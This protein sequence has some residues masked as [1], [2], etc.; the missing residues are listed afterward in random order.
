M[1]A[2]FYREKKR[3]G[4]NI[5][6]PGYVSCPTLYNMYKNTQMYEESNER[7]NPSW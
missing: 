1:N 7:T 6:F 4:K 3:K 5:N 2:I